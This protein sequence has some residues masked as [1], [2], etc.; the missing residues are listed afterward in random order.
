MALEEPYTALAD[1]RA[2]T[3]SS[4]SSLDTWYETCINQASR[5]VDSHC[6][7]DFWFHDHSSTVYRLDRARVIGGMAILPFPV[8]TLTSLWVFSDI[9]A[10]AT[11]N[12]LYATDEY[13]YEVGSPTI[14]AEAENVLMFQR[15]APGDAVFGS[16]P[17]KGF[18]EVEGTFGYTLSVSNPTTTP[19]PTIPQEVRRATTLIAA[20]ISNENR[21]EVISLDGGIESILDTRIPSEATMLLKRWREMIAYAL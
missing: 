14:R 12:D 7:R 20:A 1:V 9:N 21:K 5:M 16:Y 18:L 17:F 8:I 2:E 3:K 13:Y 11:G 10:G 15:N 6:H 19:P 4:S